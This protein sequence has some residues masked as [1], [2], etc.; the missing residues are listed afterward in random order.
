VG[1]EPVPLPEQT[2]E[3]Q[4]ESTAMADNEAGEPTAPADSTVGQ[5]TDEVVTSDTPVVTAESGASTDTGG[6]AQGDHAEQS[7]QG[8]VSTDRSLEIVRNYSVRTGDTL[9]DISGALWGDPYAWPLMLLANEPTVLDPDMLSPGQLLLVPVFPDTPLSES[10]R[11]LMTDAHL[12]AYSRYRELG[13]HPQTTS[14][15]RRN[16]G[17]IRINKSLWVLYSG[18]RYNRDLVAQL[19]DQLEPDDA[20]KVE[21][22]IARFGYP[23]DPPGH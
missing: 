7:Q 17:P 4:T 1:T 13:L 2:S 15:V 12:L 14:S 22:F 18:L 21:A 10:G 5:P 8:N 11:R 20:A 6:P 23:P 16:L 3:E 9:F 19:R